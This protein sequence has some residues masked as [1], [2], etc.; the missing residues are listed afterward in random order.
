[1]HIMYI[2]YIIPGNASDGIH[3][4][5]NIL[6][7]GH[8]FRADLDPRLAERLHHSLRIDATAVAHLGRDVHRVGLALFVATLLLEPGNGIFK[9]PL[10]TVLT[11]SRP[12][13]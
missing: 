12:W 8:P 6:S 7:L 13:S 3:R 9:P 10:K 5:D 11:S 2:K 1:M 4:L